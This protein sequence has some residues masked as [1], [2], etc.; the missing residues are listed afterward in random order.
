MNFYDMINIADKEMFRK[1]MREEDSL[2][3]DSYRYAVADIM[4]IGRAHV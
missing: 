4:E 3:G 1:I 2:D